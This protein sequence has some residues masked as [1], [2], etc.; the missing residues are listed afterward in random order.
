MGLPQPGAGMDSALLG[1]IPTRAAHGGAVQV[2]SC[3]GLRCLPCVLGMSTPQLLLPNP[4][5]EPLLSIIQ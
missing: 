2:A 4:Y 3:L 1:F 5:V